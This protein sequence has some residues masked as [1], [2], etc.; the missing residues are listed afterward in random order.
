M[1]LCVAEGDTIKVLL[2]NLKGGMRWIQPFSKE[3]VILVR[4]VDLI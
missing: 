2:G 1:R 3:P 4:N